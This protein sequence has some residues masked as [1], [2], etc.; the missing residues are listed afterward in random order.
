MSVHS[1]AEYAHG[2]SKDYEAPSRRR[3]RA[4]RLDSDHADSICNT[5]LLPE[6]SREADRVRELYSSHYRSGYDKERL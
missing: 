1:A 3:A 5:D 6:Q 4:G 2:K